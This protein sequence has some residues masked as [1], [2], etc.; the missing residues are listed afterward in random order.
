MCSVQLIFLLISYPSFIAKFIISLILFYLCC[1]IFF[2]FYI[3]ISFLCLLCFSYM[4][5]PFHFIIIFFSNIHITYFPTVKLST[6]LLSPLLSVFHT[7]VPTLSFRKDFHFHFLFVFNSNYI[8][9][10]LIFTLNS[11]LLSIKTVRHIFQNQT[12]LSLTCDAFSSLL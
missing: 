6:A 11:F 2:F 10:L 8:H 1:N 9:F 4:Y 5:F 3:V 12:A 7:A